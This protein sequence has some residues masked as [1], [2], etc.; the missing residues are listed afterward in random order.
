[1]IHTFHEYLFEK[2]SIISLFYELALLRYDVVT[3]VSKSQLLEIEKN[4]EIR[5]EK[6][7]IRAGVTLKGRFEKINAINCNLKQKDNLSLSF[8]GNLS[9]P[10]KVKGVELLIDAVKKVI[11]DYPNT[12]LFIVGEGIFKGY[13]RELVENLELEDSIIFLGY[14]NNVFEIL[15][16]SDIYTHIGYNESLGITLLE[17][18]YTRTPIIAL[19]NG[20][21]PEVI[22]EDRN[23]ILVEDNSDSIAKA[24]IELYENKSKMR[25]ISFIGHK[26][27]NKYFSWIEIGNDFVNLYL[28]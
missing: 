5:A 3:F 24:I 4:L 15:Q 22:N 20:A 28:T 23:G 26:I 6:K 11:S 19:K 17:A 21:I 12:K 1:L 2:K 7:I 10:D 8:I 27:L 13:L 18:M 9:L 25:R 14:T 16:F